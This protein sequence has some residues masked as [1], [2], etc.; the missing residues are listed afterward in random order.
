MR[1]LSV[2][3]TTHNE[4]HNIGEALESVKWADELL[5]VDSFSE[6][7]T[8]AIAKNYTD[9]VYQRVYKGPADQKNWIIPQ[10][11]HEWI[12]LLDADERISPEL[13]KEIQRWLAADDIPYDAFWIGRKNYFLGKEIRFSGWQGDQVV[14]FFRRDI[15]RYND[16]RVHEEIIT[17]GI[18]VGFLKNKMLHYTFKDSTHFLE[19]IHRYAEWSAQDHEASTT[20]VN[21]YHLLLKPLFRFFKHYILKWGFLDGRTGLIVSSIMAWG[22]FLRYLKMV[23]YRMTSPSVSPPTEEEE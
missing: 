18:R 6:D 1:P 23:E 4:A 21:A 7:N 11:S 3:L 5:V 16:K 22:V 12:L 17:E 19:K 20:K 10:A 15:C 14:R 8:V 13:K 2:I 9:R